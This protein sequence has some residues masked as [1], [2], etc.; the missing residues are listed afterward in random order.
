MMTT[1]GNEQ[2]KSSVSA[3]LHEYA[4][5]K[6]EGR[7]ADA[8]EETVRGWLNQLLAL[9]G[10]DVLDTSQ[11][12]Q[13]KKLTKAEAANAGMIGS[14]ATRPDYTFRANKQK[15]TFLDAKSLDVRIENDAEAAYQVRAYGW[16]IGAPCAFVSNFEEFAILD[17][18]I[19]PA[20]GQRPDI[21]RIYIRME[22]YADNIQTLVKCLS[23]PNVVAGSLFDVF[24]GGQSEERGITRISPDAKFASEL[25]AFRLSLAQEILGQNRDQIAGN[26]ELLGFLVQVVMNRIIFVRVCEARGIEPEGL[27]RDFQRAGFWGSFSTSCYGDFYNHYDGPLFG[28]IGQFA[29]LTVRDTVF[30]R[31]LDLLYYPSPYRFDVLPIA[32]FGDIY[33]QFLAKKLAISGDDVIEQ[34]K[35]EYIKTNGAITTP[36][37]IVREVVDRT[38]PKEHVDRNGLKSLFATTVLDFACGSGAFLTTAFSHLESIA[39]ALFDQG[40]EP[41]VDGLFLRSAQGTSLTIAGKRRLLRSCIFGVDIDAEAV[42]VARMALSLLTVDALDFRE[43]YHSLGVYGQRILSEVGANIRCGNTLVSSDIVD[44]YPQLI[45]DGDALRKVNPFDW[46][47]SS[48]FPDVFEAKGGFDY[49]VSNPPYAEV[50]NYNVDMPYMFAYVKQNYGT[51]RNGK[52]DLAVPFIERGVSL[53]NSEGRMGLVVQKRFFKT[54]YGQ[55]VRAFLTARQLLSSIVDFQST[56]IFK[57]RNTYIASVVLDKAGSSDVEYIL[58]DEKGT[59]LV[60]TLSDPEYAQRASSERVLYPAEAF[61]ANPWVFGSAQ[62]S[63]LRSSLLSKYGDLSDA[64]KFR[65]GIQALWDTAYQ[66][67]VRR[68][69][70]NYLIGDTGLEQNVRLE[71]NACRAL[72]INQGFYPFRSDETKTF[73]LF[74]YDVSDGQVDEILFTEFESRYPAAGG[75][76]ARHKSTV[77]SN[78]QT[79]PGERWHLFTRVQNHGATFPKVLVPMTAL[80]TFAT[81]TLRSDLYCDNAN[82]YFLELR[83]RQEEFLWAM[84]AIINSSL[85]STLARDVA[86]PQSGGYFKFNKQFLDPMPFPTDRFYG[87]DP[88]FISQLAEASRG[89][90]EVQDRYKNGTPTQ[91][92]AAAIQLQSLWNRL[93]ECVVNLYE[94]TLDDLQHIPKL[95]RNV[96]RIS[97][98][99]TP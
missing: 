58:R 22:Q 18:T 51:A 55:H 30:D 75:Y 83:N 28:R 38:I 70:G 10:W 21:G 40:A 94:L 78:V 90:R 32:M 59:D 63:A 37:F 88:A 50:K 4:R 6:R 93:D 48:G 69:E 64:V 96:S 8:S 35:P 54:D 25:S 16:S 31:L 33:E 34:L 12:T 66:I 85:F 13:E 24:G 97:L 41:P 20:H 26:S 56:S 87:G 5:Y 39:L 99:N 49:V 57:D 44:Q 98:L 52:V 27:L 53:L 72:F 14:S 84:A 7:L 62:L 11:V 91:R 79:H 74:P 67:I 61:G 2:L 86:N 82:M 60:A 1:A 76:L 36:S 77:T 19:T 42:E 17:C 47:Q 3:L 95:G 15:I 23:R 68:V 73:V 80:D 71:A 46:E 65:V 9:F 81:V 29:N 45:E 43:D 89:V 92:A